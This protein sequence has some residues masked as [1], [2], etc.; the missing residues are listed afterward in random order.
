M[1][2]NMKMN[3][4][5]KIRFKGFTDDWEENILGEF[6]SVAMNKRIFKEQTSESG[7]V[8]FYKIGTFGGVPDAYIS[9]NLF[10]EYKIKYSYPKIGDILISASGSIG[11]IVEHM[12]K[13]EYFQDSNIVWFD[14]DNR[15]NNLFL[16][17]F[18]LRIK[19]Y[20]LEGSTIKRLY[21]KNFVSTEI[22]YPKNPAEQTKIGKFFK[23]LDK[24]ITLEQDKYNKLINIKKSM[25]EKMFPKSGDNKPEIR[26]KEFTDDWE[27][28]EF[29]NIFDDSI[30]HNTLSR[31]ELNYENGEVKSFHYG[32]ILIKYG[33]ITEVNRAIIPFITKGTAISYKNQ[34][35]KN[36]DILMADTAEDETVGKATEIVRIENNFLVSGLHTIVCRPRYSFQPYYLGYY[37]NSPSYRKQLLP[38]MQGIKVLSISKT[39]LS[40]TSVL[41]PMFPV[42]QTK[43]GKFFKDLDKLIILHQQ[44]LDKLKNIKKSCLEKMFV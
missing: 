3:K 29:T 1:V 30:S 37:I 31:A 13:D 7:D 4:K 20:G 33:A 39:N 44:K 16:K 34:F 42:E 15:L 12:G 43:I 38:L 14:H 5:P 18:Y 26:F 17:S 22:I 21:N 28:K 36:G 23:D 10:N 35:L 9:K 2:S 27:R 11:K 40:K 24:R 8:P 19:W 6:G 25:L 32:D 41:Y